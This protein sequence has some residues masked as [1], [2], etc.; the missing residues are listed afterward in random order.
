[1]Y[2]WYQIAQ[3]I[4]FALFKEDGKLDFATESLKLARRTSAN[5][6]AFSLII[7]VEM[8]V[9]WHALEV[10]NIKMSVR[11]SLFIFKKENG[12]LGFLLHILE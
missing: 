9:S 3:N 2:K 6:A 8:S 5:I 11:S 12:N 10:S 1:M 4:T 7:Y